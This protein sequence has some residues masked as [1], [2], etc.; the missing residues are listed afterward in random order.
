MLFTSI[1]INNKEAFNDTAVWNIDKIDLPYNQNSLSFDFIAMANNNPGQ[2]IYQYRMK[3][4]DDQWIQNNELQ[5]VR[6]YLPPGKYLFQLY[7]SRF[8]DKDAKPMNEISITIHPPFWKTWWFLTILSAVLITAMYYALN[9]YNRRKYRNKLRELEN[10]HRIQ[11][12][13]ERIS[14]DLHDSIGAYANAV[15]YNTELLEKQDGPKQKDELMKDL[16]FAS[17][18]IITSL[19][20]TIWAL[21]KDNYTP[22]DCLLRIRNFVQPFNRYYPHIQF[23]VEGEASS[24]RQLHYTKALNVVRIV[25]EAI[26]NSIKHAAATNII[27]TSNEKEGRWELTVSDDGK[28]FNEQTIKSEEQGNGLNNMKKGLPIPVSIC[29]FNHRMVEQKFLS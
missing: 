16:K 27:I 7:A 2:Y 6:Y 23:K 3:G 4:I 29:L 1:K 11:M 15:L 22:E 13:R 21:K 8:F 20:A 19:R 17:K 28:G 12:E 10:E 25:Q 18:D 9:Q 24:Q 26:T 14:L 5:T